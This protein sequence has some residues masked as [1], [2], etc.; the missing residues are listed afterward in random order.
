MRIAVIGVGGVGGYFG[1]RLAQAG[2]EVTFIARGETLRALRENGLRVE[3]VDG[4]M[5]IQPAAATYDPAMVGTVDIVLAG[6]EGL[7]GAGS[8]RVHAPAD[9][10]RYDSGPA[11]Q[12]RRGARSTGSGLWPGTRRRRTLRPLRR[13]RRAGAYPQRAATALHQLWHARQHTQR[14]AGA[15]A[16]GVRARSASGRRLRRIS[17]PRSGRNCSSS[18]RSAAWERSPAR[19][20]ASFARC[21]RR[22]PY[23]KAR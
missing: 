5:L 10:F 18:V 19:L 2:E 20:L 23:W 14:A 3:S 8:H 17:A 1:A 9:G 21:R 6:G 15:I 16:G 7:A 13:H 11:A 22:A 4:D 12:R